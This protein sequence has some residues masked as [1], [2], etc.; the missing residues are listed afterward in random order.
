MIHFPYFVSFFLFLLTFQETVMQ[1]YRRY[2]RFKDIVGKLIPRIKCTERKD[3]MTLTQKRILILFIIIV[4]AAVLGRVVFRAFL[5][6][7]LGGTM[8]GGNFL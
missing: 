7:L 4:I 2:K 6:F 3:K 8:F 5:N 1:L